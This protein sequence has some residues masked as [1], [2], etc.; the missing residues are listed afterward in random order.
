MLFQDAVAHLENPQLMRFMA[1]FLAL[2]TA[3]IRR[4]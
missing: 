1:S 4:E 2:F 3:D